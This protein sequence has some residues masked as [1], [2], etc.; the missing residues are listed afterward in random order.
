MYLV[1][2]NLDLTNVK[3]RDNM[4]RTIKGALEEIK[5]RDPKTAITEYAIRRMVKQNEIPYSRSGKKY[6]I[7][8]ENVIEYFNGNQKINAENT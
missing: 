5:A 8:V 6:L 1:F 3:G 7:N 2:C 4:Y